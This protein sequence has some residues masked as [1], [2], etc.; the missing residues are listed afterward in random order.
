MAK[1]QHLQVR[2]RTDF[3]VTI[4]TS[5]ETKRDYHSRDTDVLVGHHLPCNHTQ[6]IYDD[7][8]NIQAEPANM[9]TVADQ[10]TPPIVNH[11]AIQGIAKF[12]SQHISYNA[13]SSYTEFE[14]E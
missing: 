14:G 9:V 11:N 7:Q 4:N 3:T 6:A 10:A 13:P 12:I 8:N 1:G 5:I 2:I